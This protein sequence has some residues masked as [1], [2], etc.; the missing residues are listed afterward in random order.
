MTELTLTRSFPLPPEQVFEFIT[1]RDR[2]L[3]WWGPEGTT[4]PDERLDFTAEGPWHSVI[5]NADGRRF[6]VSGEVV[7]VSPPHTIQF[8]WGW[9]DETD[10][11][12]PESRVRI[13]LHAEGAGTRFVLRHR[14]LADAE[15]RSNHELGWTSSLGKLER[16]LR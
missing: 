6:K 10:A 16:L 8:T 2:L 9:H 15:S 11:R 5:M 12:G 4:L 1:R 7:E 13:E 14:E 3:Q